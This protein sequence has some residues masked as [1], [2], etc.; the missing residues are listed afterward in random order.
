MVYRLKTTRD[1]GRTR[2]TFV[3]HDFIYNTR[4]EIEWDRM[5]TLN[6]L[7]TLNVEK[8]INLTTIPVQ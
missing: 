7:P 6:M 4:S 1:V 3:N 2:E 5:L 8:A